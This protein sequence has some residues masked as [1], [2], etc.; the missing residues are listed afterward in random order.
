MRIHHLSCGT[1]CPYGRALLN[2]TGSAFEPAEICCHC[3]LIESDE[4][5]VLVDTGLGSADL[6]PKNSRIPLELRVL[7]RPVLDP[8]RS[9][10]AQVQALGFSAGDVRHL[11]VTHLD[12]DHAGGISDFPEALVHVYAREHHA[13]TQR[14]DFMEKR[15]YL[16]RQWAHGPRWNA[17]SEDGEA[18]FGFEAV[19]ALNAK[20]TDILLVPVVGHSRG[21]CAVAVRTDSGYLLHCGDAYFHRDEMNPAP[22]CP[23]GFAFFQQAMAHDNGRRVHNQARLRALKAAH[24][25]EVQLF[26]AHD[27]VELAAF[28][29]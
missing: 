2:G 17:L 26:S 16:K 7:M 9:A 19:R 25:K 13:A 12:F 6:S 4:G 24:G 14:D 22:S 23:K 20:E 3:L 10:L 8:S 18:F 5:L 11:V 28:Q 27:P 29:R 21:H 1:L 15:R